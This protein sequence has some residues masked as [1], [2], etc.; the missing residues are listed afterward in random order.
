MKK[1]LCIITAFALLLGMLT[2]CNKNGANADGATTADGTESEQTV[3]REQIRGVLNGHL[4]SEFTIIY[5]ASEPDYTQRAAT[6]L[7]DEIVERTGV[8]LTVK[9][10]AEQTETLEHEIVIGNTNRAISTELDI[11]KEQLQFSMLADDNHIAMEGDYFVIA[12]AAYYFVE[13][14]IK[15][16]AFESTIAKEETVHDP[17]IKKTENIIYL[18]GDGMGINQTYLHNCYTAKD[19]G[20]LSDG[21]NLFYGH[22][23]P[24]L[25]YARTPSLSGTTDSAAGGT[26]LATGYKTYNGYLGKDKDLKDV[27]SLTEI[28][29]E[30]GKST[31]VMTT[32]GIT[33]ATPA[34][35]SS[36]ASSR[37]D[38][39]NITAGQNELMQKYGTIILGGY[40]AKYAKDVVKQLESDYQNTLATLSKNENGFFIMYEE[41]HIDKHCHSEDLIRTFYA[42]VRF[43]QIIGLSME[44][45]F[46]NPETMV[47]I[48]AD[49]ETGGMIIGDEGRCQFTY[50][51]HT[52]QEVP[53][54]AYGYY[55][56]IFDKVT[57]ENIQIPKTLAKL[58]GGQ[59]V[60]YEDTKYPALS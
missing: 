12:A 15:D 2:G 26:A 11:E 25:G 28:A 3:S 5:A 39:A 14:Y 58:M 49:H 37:S 48:T 55:A 8:L 54:F 18:I 33:G 16:E 43:N 4:L 46:Y 24:Y 27:K 34:A 40:D 1:F 45:A 17:I 36:H 22:M 9:S 6:Y 47:L 30:V 20:L 23:L 44:Y 57:I 41:A 19:H 32:E 38:S 35:F 56:K 52:N 53:V 60:G 7:C 42:M 29:I 13:N 21:E 50:D 59:M 31:A 10:D 51:N